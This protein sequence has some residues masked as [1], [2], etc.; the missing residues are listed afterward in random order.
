MEHSRELGSDFVL[1][2]QGGAFQ[3]YDGRGRKRSIV[4]PFTGLRRGGTGGI[5]WILSEKRREDTA[6]TALHVSQG[7]GT[8]GTVSFGDTEEEPKKYGG[9][10]ITKRQRA[11][12]RFV[13]VAA[14][15]EGDAV[16]AERVMELYRNAVANKNSLQTARD[17]F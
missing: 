2:I 14:S 4:R 9:K 5:L 3:V 1:R 10:E 17:P 16:T 6:G 8:G 7:Q 11:Y 12:N 13:I 15:L